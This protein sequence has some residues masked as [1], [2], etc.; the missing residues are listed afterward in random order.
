MYHLLQ[1]GHTHTGIGG[2]IENAIGN[3]EHRNHLGGENVIQKVVGTESREFPVTYYETEQVPVQR[4]KI[5]NREVTEEVPVIREEART[6]MVPVEHVEIRTR[7][8]Q[9]TVP[10]EILIWTAA[11][12]K[13]SFPFIAHVTYIWYKHLFREVYISFPSEVWF[14]HYKST[15]NTRWD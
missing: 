3:L 7:I 8:V 15:F 1:K 4:E 13:L 14:L 9:E 11:E 5:V 6:V 10:G 2:K 12:P